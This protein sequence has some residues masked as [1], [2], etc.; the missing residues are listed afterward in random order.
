MLVISHCPVALAAGPGT[1]IDAG[2][3]SGTDGAS[4]APAWTLSGTPQRAEYDTTRARSGSLSGW[5]QGPAS[6]IAGASAP[7]VMTSDG[8]EYRFW[9]FADTANENRYISDTASTFEMRLNASG[10]L[11]IYTKRTATG[12]TPNAFNTVGTYAA[13]WTEYRVVLDFTTDTYQL[14]KRANS[15]DPWTQLKASGAATY[16]IPMREATDRTT[17]AALLFRGYNGSSMWLDEVRYSDTGI[18]DPVPV[19]HTITSSAGPNGSISPAGAQTVT[20][21]SSAVFTITPGAGHQI[22][23]V[24]VDGASVGAVGTYTFSNVTADHTI[25]A[26]F[27]AA[28]SEM[29]IDVDCDGCHAMPHDDYFIECGECHEFADYHPGTASS[30]HYP[31]DVIACTPCHNASLTLEHNGRTPD[32]G[33]PF[34][35]LTC[36]NSGN[37]LVRNAINVNAS[38]CSACHDSAD[39]HYGDHDTVLPAVSCQDAGCHAGTNLLPIHSALTCAECHQ[40]PDSNVTGAIAA[41]DKRCAT[42]HPTAQADH[43]ALHD[44]VLPAVSC[45]DVGCH[46]GTNLLPIHSALTCAECHQSPDT[47]V[48]GAIAAGDKRCATCHPGGAH[49]ASH[50]AGL[51]RADCL[52]CHRPNISEEHGNDCDKCHESSDP[53]VVEAIFTGHVACGS[54]HTPG[55]HPSGFFSIKTDYYQWTTTPGPRGSGPALGTV[56][57]NPSNPGAHA[58]YLATTAKCGMCHSVHRAAGAGTKLLP[59]ADASCAGCHTGGTAVTAKIITWTPYDT[60]WVPEVD[61]ASPLAPIGSPAWMAA[62]G[63]QRKDA[64][65]NQS[66]AGGAANGG[67]PHNDSALDLIADGVWDGI[68]PTPAPDFDGARYG[69]LTRRCHATNPHGAGASKY[70]IFAAKL[71][72]NEPADDDQEGEGTYG[73][74][75]AVWDDIGATDAAVERFVAA[76]P[77]VMSVSGGDILINGALPDE[78][79]ARALVA[80]LTCGRPSNASTGEDECHAEATYAIVDKGIREQRNHATGITQGAAYRTDNTGAEAAGYGGNDNRD[81]KTGHVA[82]TFAAVPGA[83]SYSPIAGCTSCHDQTDSANTVAGHYTFPHGQTAAG[84]SN[85]TSDGVQPY[86]GRARI[87]SGYADDAQ[88]ALLPVT[89][90]GQKAYDGNCLKCH[91]DGSGNGIGLTR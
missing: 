85:V 78:N 6:G 38:N 41:G 7:V 44:T 17:T 45:Q 42:C 2:F 86:T 22:A 67:G 13:G 28:P 39:A 10:Q 87:W 57:D 29:L 53:A 79:Q 8:A 77:A 48:T 32:A 55:L 72:F 24:L 56:G 51:L 62:T 81:W 76:N 65:T 14:S 74:L 71:L 11:M 69:C 23:D 35:C 84:E 91:R 46:A 63:S 89:G 21:G 26:T 34:T 18:S 61:P 52:E 16:A 54:C 30:I 19:T 59:T 83:A 36:H 33:G 43:A 88:D 12:Y 40:S 3:E 50:D 90:T 27:A 70:T 4:L 20:E 68:G 5:I 31:A 60:H 47:V 66:A 58:N 64:I 80:G 37:P 82:G 1:L 25:S 73:G 75:D 49:P 15:A 9:V